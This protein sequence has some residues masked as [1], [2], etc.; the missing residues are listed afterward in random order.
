MRREEEDMK[1]IRKKQ[2][3]QMDMLNGSLL[4]KILLFALPLGASSILQ[5]LF[6][7]A[8]V[9]VVGRFAGSVAQAAVGCNASIINLLVNLFVGLSVGANA[10][11][12]NYIGQKNESRIQDAVHTVIL[13]AVYSGIALMVLGQVIARPLLLLQNTPQDVLG[14]AILY[15]RI[16]FIGMPFIMVYNF[17]SAVLRSKGD[18]RRPLYALMISG[19]INVILNLFLVITFRLG[20]AGVAIATV[21]SNVVSS[22][23]VFYF[24]MTEEL[25]FRLSLKKLA[26]EKH[27]LKRVIRIGLPAGI[28]GMVFP[29]SNMCIQAGINSFG[30]SAIAASTAALNFEYFSYY[31]INAFASAAVTFTSQ[32]YGAG[33]KERCRRVFWLCMACGAAI[34][35]SLIAIFMMWRGVLIR[36]YTIDEAVITLALARM[37][38]VLTLEWIPTAY[39]VPASAMRGLGYS[40]MPAVITILGT[41]LFRVFWVTVVFAR[42][43][44]FTV[45]MD[46]Y[47]VSWIVTGAAMMAAY[48]VIWRKVR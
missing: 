28:Q 6:N 34:S 18:T 2:S 42:L 38:H 23:M 25:P 8:D 10:V 20:V 19:V 44:T 45:L 1:K 22:G 29:I 7:S 41:C 30:A 35:G 3:G 46:V 13:L 40:V 12:A 43:G 11:I 15:L 32:N 14:Q 24:L 21:V 36:I 31:V 16:Y 9:A 39:E 5:A 27:S 33:K 47:P 26:F 4:D 17:G 48:F 37:V